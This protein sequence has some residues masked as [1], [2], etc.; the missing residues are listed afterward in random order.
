MILG[1]GTRFR[2]MDTGCVRYLSYEMGRCAAKVNDAPLCYAIQAAEVD[3]NPTLT[4]HSI[5]I[6]TLHKAPDQGNRN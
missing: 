6:V 2:D 1:Y 4:W 5:F 3:T